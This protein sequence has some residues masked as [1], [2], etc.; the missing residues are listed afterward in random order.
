[1]GDAPSGRYPALQDQKSNFWPS[2]S[3]SKNYRRL[4]S[5][6][7]GFAV[8]E[9]IMLR[10]L[11][12]SASMA[13][14]LAFLASAT[15]TLT[16]LDPEAQHF[17]SVL[18]GAIQHAESNQPQSVVDDL[19]PVVGAPGY[20]SL[21]SRYQFAG[22]LMLGGAYYDLHQL[23]QSWDALKHATSFPEADG[24]AWR[25]RFFAAAELHE[26]EDVVACVEA[27]GQHFPATLQGIDPD[28]I[29][30]IQRMIRSAPTSDVLLMRFY[31]SLHDAQYRATD[32]TVDNSYRWMDLARLLL[33]NGQADRARQVASEVTNADEIL[34]MAV[35]HRFDGIVADR[36]SSFAQLYENELARKRA[37]IR[38]NPDRLEHLND[39]IWLLEQLDRNDEALTLADSAIARS[40][41]SQPFSDQNDYLNWTH[42][43]RSY[44]L[45]ALGR[46]DEAI[47]EMRIGA[48]EQEH[49]QANV[50][51]L[52]NLA[53]MQMRV[54]HNSDAIATLGALDDH[55]VSGY[56]WM[57]A[58]YVL[59][60][61]HHRAGEQEAAQREIAAMR[62]RTA[63]S[64][65][66]MIGTEICFGN[67]DEA[68]HL[69]LADLANPEERGVSLMMMQT[70]ITHHV[71]TEADRDFQRGFDTL[72]AR[73]DVSA[74]IG[75]YG[76]LLSLPI[77][78]GNY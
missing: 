11:V 50:S 18:Q 20:D 59:A 67:S 4:S 57:N 21:P 40:S 54:G 22:Y 61:A 41:T 7:L 78:R 72:R 45:L 48:H 43:A 37:I 60:C 49:G 26:L 71:Q 5:S 42:N 15:P 64:T 35:D 38:T 17:R 27:L 28:V 6:P 69:Y 16:D 52:I 25:L 76:R 46:N 74:A 29:G 1:M 39:L 73:S 75:R 36:S 47:A 10:S 2:L 31:N 30:Q 63:D 24:Q 55:H 14:G 51:Q 68:A 44:A 77:R 66:I 23:P 53:E 62:A 56:G 8:V 70:F 58:H 3:A 12:L 13:L 33:D 9:G 32:P 19:R 34:A 65:T